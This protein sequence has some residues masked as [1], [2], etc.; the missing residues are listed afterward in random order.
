MTK[1]A[2]ASTNNAPY[3][4]TDTFLRSVD[5]IYQ[6]E[7][8]QAKAFKIQMRGLGKYYLPTLEDFVP[9]FEKYLGIDKK[10]GK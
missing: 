6:F 3:V 2:K 10:E 7:N 5:S 8:I 1:S 9:Y 4:S